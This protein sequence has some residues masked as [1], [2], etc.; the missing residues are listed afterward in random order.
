MKGSER[1]LMGIDWW[2]KQRQTWIWIRFD[3]IFSF[4]SVSVSTKHDSIL[5]LHDTPFGTSY[6]YEPLISVKN[7][8]SPKIT[9]YGYSRKAQGWYLGRTSVKLCPY[10]LAV[11]DNFHMLRNYLPVW[12]THGYCYGLKSRTYRAL[13]IWAAT[14]IGERK[15]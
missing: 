3:P 9:S 8:N 5:E 12:K 10:Y 1:C 4:V 7:P 11:R 13:L 6:S 2:S 15:F 14:S